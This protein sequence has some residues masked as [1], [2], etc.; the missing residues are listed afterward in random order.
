MDKYITFF[1]NAKFLML[2]VRLDQDLAKR[3]QQQQTCRECGSRLHFARYYR[4]FRLPGTE[5]LEVEGLGC[6]FGLCCS[7]EECRRRH[8]PPSLR[9]P[10]SSPNF[11]GLVALVDFFNAPHSKLKAQKLCELTGMS[12]RTVRRWLVFWRRSAT[13][14][15]WRKL[16]VKFPQLRLPHEL[17]PE[18]PGYLSL[19]SW[20]YRLSILFGELSTH[21]ARFNHP[22]K[23]PAAGL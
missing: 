10:G 20:L 19:L 9:F 14:A 17:L 7:N 15:W 12:L 11:L 21:L 23:M 4:K 8:R 1:M 2:L 16:V 22:H 3:F 13:S 6:F 18:V 5:K